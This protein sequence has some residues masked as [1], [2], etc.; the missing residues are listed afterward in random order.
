MISK[1]C[2]TKAQCLVVSE[3]HDIFQATESEARPVFV[4]SLLNRE[5]WPFMFSVFIYIT[6]WYQSG[7]SSYRIHWQVPLPDIG[8]ICESDIVK[9]TLITELTERII[10]VIRDCGDHKVISWHDGYSG[11]HLHSESD[12]LQDAV[13]TGSDNSVFILG[14]KQIAVLNSDGRMDVFPTMGNKQL[15]QRYFY[16]VDTNASL[17]EGFSLSS[18]MRCIPTWKLGFDG[19]LL[20]C[21]IRLFFVRRD[22]RLVGWS[23]IQTGSTSYEWI[24]V[25]GKWKSKILSCSLNLSSFSCVGFQIVFVCAQGRWENWACKRENSVGRNVFS[26]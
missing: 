4:K 25:S 5:L 23:L 1:V 19:R 21:T 7:V 13:L 18:S 24:S 16:S 22:V 10:A 26:S 11:Q 12:G 2:F 3:C 17:L 15:S 8:H 14:P 9:W 20:E 6:V